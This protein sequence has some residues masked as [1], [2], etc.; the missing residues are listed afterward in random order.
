MIA[1]MSKGCP[2]QKSMEVLVVA[3]MVATKFQL[4]IADIL[5]HVR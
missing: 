3:G 5:W 2:Q 1:E 4:V